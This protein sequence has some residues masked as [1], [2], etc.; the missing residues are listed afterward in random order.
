MPKAFVP[1]VHRSYEVDLRPDT[2]VINFF[3][4]F[5]MNI[6]WYWTMFIVVE[7]PC[8][9]LEFEH[10]NMDWIALITHKQYFI[11]SLHFIKSTQDQ[12]SG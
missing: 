7:L 6:Y 11:S 4:I 8:L 3:Y 2:S 9:K 10:K 1:L 5:Y 12:D